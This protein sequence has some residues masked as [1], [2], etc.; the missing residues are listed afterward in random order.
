MITGGE[1]AIIE[2]INDNVKKLLINGEVSTAYYRFQYITEFIDKLS[3]FYEDDFITRIETY[4]KLYYIESVNG[5]SI[6]DMN[7]PKITKEME[8]YINYRISGGLPY[9]KL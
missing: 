4:D 6:T 8:K 2:I 7:M 1:Y 3:W 5:L 9:I